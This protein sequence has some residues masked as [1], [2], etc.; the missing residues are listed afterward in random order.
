LLTNIFDGQPSELEH[1]RYI[2]RYLNTG[3][4]TDSGADYSD[5]RLGMLD[6]IE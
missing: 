1:P 4:Y 3:T 2:E 6:I 5:Y